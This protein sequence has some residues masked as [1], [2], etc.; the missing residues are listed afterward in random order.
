VKRC[1]SNILVTECGS[2]NAKLLGDLPKFFCSD[3]SVM[4]SG[5]ID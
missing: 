4:V 3:A 5:N 1:S 2:D